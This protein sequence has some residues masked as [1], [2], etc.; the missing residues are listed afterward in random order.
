[1]WDERYSGPFYAT[2]KCVYRLSSQSMNIIG[3]FLR[4]LANLKI[5]DETL[6]SATY[7]LLLDSRS[8]DDVG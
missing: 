5:I 7:Y 6:G 1:M 8:K 3:P 2:T 4:V